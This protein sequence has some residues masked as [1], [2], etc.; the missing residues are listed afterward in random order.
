MQGQG[1]FGRL[2]FHMDHGDVLTACREYLERNFP[3]L[4]ATAHDV[5][6]QY[7]EIAFPDCQDVGLD[8]TV[9]CTIEFL[10]KQEWMK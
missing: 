1:D 8:G 9:V 7:H 3:K 2:M 6:V 4:V 5:D 10:G